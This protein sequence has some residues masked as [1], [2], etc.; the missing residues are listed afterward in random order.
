MAGW[1]GKNMGLAGRTTLVKSVLTS[2]PVYLLTA[3]KVNNESLEVL[4]KQWSR[5]LWAESGDTTEGKC[6]V[7][8]EKTS[9]PTVNGGGWGS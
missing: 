9:S 7:N 2:Q 4:D 3:L 8:W 5:F 1:R 6:K